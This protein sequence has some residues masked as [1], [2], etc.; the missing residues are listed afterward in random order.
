MTDIDRFLAWLVPIGGW[1][2]IHSNDKTLF[3]VEVVA[4][5]R[6]LKVSHFYDSSMLLGNG[7]GGS[8]KAREQL[9]TREITFSGSLSAGHSGCCNTEPD[10][11]GRWA[12]LF[13]QW[14]CFLMLS[15]VWEPFIQGPSGQKK[16]TIC[17]EMLPFFL[18]WGRKEF[19]QSQLWYNPG[20][21][22]MLQ[23]I[24]SV[25]TLWAS[26]LQLFWSTLDMATFPIWM[27]NY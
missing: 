1:K 8:S 15:V 27:S 21:W 23:Q 22:N 6:T 26:N 12:F 2:L 5:G 24:C 9:F 25:L 17:Q 7:G 18:N 19:S 14:A 20:T 10:H 4:K 13:L 16:E 3:T 11:T